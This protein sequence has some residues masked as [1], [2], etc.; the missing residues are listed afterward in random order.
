MSVEDSPHAARRLRFWP[1][2]LTVLAAALA[3]LGLAATLVVVTGL[4][5]ASAGSPPGS[6]AP[7][8]AGLPRYEVEIGYQSVGPKGGL[9]QNASLVDT[10][11]GNHLAT[12]QP[13]PDAMFNFVA[14]SADG[15]TFVLTATAG[16]NYGPSGT[17]FT[18]SEYKTGIPA[19]D[20]WY[21]LRLNPG[22]PQQA[23]LTALPIVPIPVKN[24]GTSGIGGF[25]GMAVS[26]DGRTLAVAWTNSST[27]AVTSSGTGTTL[28]TY[29]LATGQVLHTWTGSQQYSLSGLTWLDD[30]RT[31]AFV[32]SSGDGS[33]S[34]TIHT[35]NTASPG[36]S[37]TADSRAAFSMPADRVCGSMLMTADGKAVICGS[38][39]M[40]GC[41][42]GVLNLAAYSVA[43]GKLE[44]VI[45]RFPGQCTVGLAVVQ[46]AAS[47]TLAV[48]ELV[49]TE[50][51]PPH[52][53]ILEAVGVIPSGPSASLPPKL[54]ETYN[55]PDTIAF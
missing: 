50:P 2:W 11:T 19:R 36:T 34:G 17:K 21:V 38:A 22:A 4:F 37:L 28:R 32:S 7:L 12:Y 18:S 54:G 41:T 27:S 48:A 9:V 8:S 26:P 1:R 44:R 35:L 16:P 14:G 13:A 24:G 43:T 10:S 6:T 51:T 47:S 55:G 53:Q 52:Q 3:T 40:Y 29:S 31:L 23:R 45:Y 39:P 15:T 30:D 25:G 46:W 20:I 33:G 42:D 49:Y 5:K